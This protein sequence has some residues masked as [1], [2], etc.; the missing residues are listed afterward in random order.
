MR[1]IA[2]CAS[3][4]LLALSGTLAVAAQDASPA[5]PAKSAS[6]SAPAA[7]STNP[8][9]SVYEQAGISVTNPDGTRKSDDQ[10]RK[11]LQAYYI[12]QKKAKNP[13][14]GTVFNMRNI[15]KDE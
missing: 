8:A 1:P 10:L 14:Y 9:D 11:E 3:L 6:A 4:C 7:T 2:T 12:A 15:F 13:N 5:K